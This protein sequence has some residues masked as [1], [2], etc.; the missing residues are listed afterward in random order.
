VI[1]HGIPIAWDTPE[2]IQRDER[3]IAAYLGEG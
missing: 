3:V 2:E 1:D